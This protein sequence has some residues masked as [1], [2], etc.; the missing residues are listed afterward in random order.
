MNRLNAEDANSED[1]FNA[2]DAKVG[3]EARREDISSAP[4]CENLCGLGGESGGSPV[5]VTAI[6]VWGLT[7]GVR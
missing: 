7:Y 4:L 5:L 2:E 1:F 3:A 6:P